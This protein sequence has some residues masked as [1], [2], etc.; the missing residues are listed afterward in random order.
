MRRNVSLIA[1]LCL[2]LPVAAQTVYKWVD[3]EGEVHY[4]HALPPD[5]AERAHERLAADGRVAER[6][7]RAPTQEERER[8]AAQLAVERDEAER[9]RIRASQDRLLLAA[10]PTEDHLQRSMDSELEVIESERRSV[11]SSLSSAQGYFQELVARAAELER[12]GEPVPDEL[13]GRIDSSRQSI[14]RL[15]AQLAKIDRRWAEV[16]QGFEQDLD[17]YRQL[18]SSGRSP[19]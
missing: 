19:G 3:E 6:V 5:Q 14:R 9:A 8:L 13:K 2:C 1:A 12:Q 18:N 15:T 7:D 4:S 10:Y 11:T 17:R 16:K